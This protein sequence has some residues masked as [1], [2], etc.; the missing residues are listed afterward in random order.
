[1]NTEIGASVPLILTS[2]SLYSFNLFSSLLIYILWSLCSRNTP[3]FFFCIN[4]SN[5]LISTKLLQ[6][7][8]EILYC[9][10]RHRIHISKKLIFFFLNSKNQCNQKMLLLPTKI[11][12]LPL[13]LKRITHL[14]QTEYWF[15]PPGL[16]YS[17]ERYNK[18]TLQANCYMLSLILQCSEV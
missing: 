17:S 6:T 11:W 3:K 10:L 8:T 1:M 14:L 16:W 4:S 5:K 2:F 15:I 18:T 12:I 7:S 13:I 9:C